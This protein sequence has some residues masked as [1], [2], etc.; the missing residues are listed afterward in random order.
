MAGWAGQA[1]TARIA[2]SERK[3]LKAR[4]PEDFVKAAEEIC[5]IPYLP[6]DYFQEDLSGERLTAFERIREGG[7]FASLW[8]L[9]EKCGTGMEVELSRIPL[10]Q[11]TVEISEIGLF[12]PYEADGTGS[13]LFARPSYEAA[14]ALLEDLRKR[15]IPGALIGIL[16]EGKARK[17]HQGERIRYLEKERQGDQGRRKDAD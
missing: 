5:E 12:S 6:E 11:E 1:E 4:F 3:A 17:I 7:V 15:G 9:G 14:L 2:V 13:V 8:R 16:T 10:R